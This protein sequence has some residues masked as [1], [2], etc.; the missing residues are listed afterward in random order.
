[1]YFYYPYGSTMVCYAT[2]MCRTVLSLTPAIFSAKRSHP[3]IPNQFVRK[4][5]KVK[6]CSLRL[7]P[8]S[9]DVFTQCSP[10]ER[11]LL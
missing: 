2:K 8:P 7:E 6:G 5:W 11:Y 3:Q 10:V 4:I 1:M 9:C